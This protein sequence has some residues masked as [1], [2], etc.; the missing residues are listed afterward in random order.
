[1]QAYALD[2][3]TGVYSVKSALLSQLAL[4]ACPPLIAVTAAIAVPQVRH[5]IH[6][7][8]APKPHH[9]PLVRTA[10]RPSADCVARGR[11]DANRAGADDFLRDVADLDMSE[12][13]IGAI[14][15]SALAAPSRSGRGGWNGSSPSF[16]FTPGGEWIGTPPGGPGAP[17]NPTGPNPPTGAVPE[18]SNWLFML[19]GFGVVGGTIR[20]GRRSKAKRTLG[21]GGAPILAAAFDVGAGTSLASAKVTTFGLHAARAA[22]LKKVGVC[23]CSAAALVT[24]ATTVPRVRHALYAA[25]APAAEHLPLAKPCLPAIVADE[26]TGDRS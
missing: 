13:Q 6:H 1:M 9:H 23:V 2:P 10:K 14:Q 16:G 25:T 17:T 15:A 26:A 20:S 3:S 24:T 4:C 18:P 8:T 19:L 12:P 11:T 22:A 7:A 5:A 21:A